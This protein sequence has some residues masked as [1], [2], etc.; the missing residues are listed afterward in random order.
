M[1]WVIYLIEGR[2]SVYMS[3]QRMQVPCQEWETV[4]LMKVISLYTRLKLYAGLR[5][6][7][8]TEQNNTYKTAG[9]FKRNNGGGLGTLFIGLSVIFII[10]IAFLNIVD[11]SLF[12]YKRNAIS[13][14]MDYAVTA[15]AQQIDKPG[16]ITGV[17]NGFSEITGERL[18]D[19]VQIDIDMATKAFLNIFTKNYSADNIAIDNNLLVCATSSSNKK[20]KYIVKADNELLYKGQLDD[21]VLLEKVINDAIDQ[22][23]PSSEN[24]SKVYINGNSKTNMIECGTYLFAFIKDIKIKG[25]YSE[26]NVTLSSFAGA[27]L[28]R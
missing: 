17:A 20:L 16:S 19:D 14:A 15:G 5:K 23:W 24:I 28:E 21:P 13:R 26:R 22:Y 11:Y 12:T 3:N 8:L 27:K 1:P 6:N 25:F 4:R 7:K 2:Y 10:F 18:T 9:I